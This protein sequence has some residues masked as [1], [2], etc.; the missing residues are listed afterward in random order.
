QLVRPRVLDL[1]ALTG[2]DIDAR[3]RLDGVCPPGDVDLAPAVCHVQHRDAVAGLDRTRASGRV[4]D[5]A[6]FEDLGASRGIEGA[7]DGGGVRFAQLL[8][9][10]VWRQNGGGHHYASSLIYG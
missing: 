10:L 9:Q 5:D 3:R 2:T 6:L 1:V 8:L 4:T 7:A